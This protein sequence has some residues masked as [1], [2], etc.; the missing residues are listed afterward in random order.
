MISPAKS[1][2]VTDTMMATYSGTSESV[3]IACDRVV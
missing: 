1:T 3:L 2:A